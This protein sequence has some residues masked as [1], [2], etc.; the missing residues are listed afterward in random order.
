MAHVIVNSQNFIK[1]FFFLGWRRNQPC[2]TQCWGYALLGDFNFRTS[3]GAL[4][5]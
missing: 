3:F 5:D 1:D 4:E 2:K